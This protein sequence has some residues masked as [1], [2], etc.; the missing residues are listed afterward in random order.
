MLLLRTLSSFVLL[1]GLLVSV[2]GCEKK[3]DLDKVRFEVGV[4]EPVAKLVTYESTPATDTS[5]KFHGIGEKGITLTEG[6][7]IVL[8]I[9]PLSNDKPEPLDGELSAIASG[10]TISVTNVADSDRPRRRIVLLAEQIGTGKLVI[11][12]DCHDGQVEIPITV[13]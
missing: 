1:A 6:I 5:S 2:T 7:A 12:V 9:E 10:T 4:S 13:K 8:N 3:P 11:S